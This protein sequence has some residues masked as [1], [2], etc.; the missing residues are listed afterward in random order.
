MIKGRKRRI[1]SQSARESAKIH[2]RMQTTD[3]VMMVGKEPSIH[4]ASLA[5]TVQIVD[6]G[7]KKAIHRA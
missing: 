2:V 1:L 7:L 4:H 3:H 6:L 5:Q